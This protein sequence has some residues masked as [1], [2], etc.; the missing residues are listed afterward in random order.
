M[1]GKG[2]KGYVMRPE[3]EAVCLD[4][5]IDTELKHRL[6]KELREFALNLK[7]DKDLRTS[8]PTTSAN[9]K[10]LQLEIKKDILNRAQIICTTLST[11][12]LI[13]LLEISSH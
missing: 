5:Q 7:S 8:Q 3:V 9:D 13:S 2:P 6:S 10:E 4:R 1:Q 12:Y 11:R